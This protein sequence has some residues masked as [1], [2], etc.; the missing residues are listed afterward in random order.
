MIDAPR[1]GWGRRL[2]A[3]LTDQIILFLGF[4]FTVAGLAAAANISQTVFGAASF[5][6]T[7]IRGHS[8]ALAAWFGE[9]F[10]HLSVIAAV[11]AIFSIVEIPMTAAGGRTVGKMLFN[12]KIARPNGEPPGFKKALARW[13]LLYLPAVVPILVWMTRWRN[14]PIR[15]PYRG[16]PNDNA[17]LASIVDQYVAYSNAPFIVIGLLSLLYYAYLL[18]GER[19]LSKL[20]GTVVITDE[21]K[22]TSAP[23]PPDGAGM[24]QRLRARLLDHLFYLPVTAALLL[25]ITYNPAGQ[26]DSLPPIVYWQVPFVSLPEG[27]GFAPWALAAGWLAAGAVPALLLEV[28]LTALRGQTP[29]KTI[30]KIR[31]VR[32]SDGRPPGWGRSLARWAALYIPLFIPVV[33]WLIFPL[34]ALSPLFHPR[35]RGW[36]DLLAGTTAAPVE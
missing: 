33:G 9:P 11:L 30:M 28:P 34:T 19:G 1:A 20:T 8:F 14:L 10:F 15:E 25:L 21:D 26:A 3:R 31:A 7:L 36:H 13:G 16:D 5:G 24:T 35:R 4:I 17:A 2:G 32:A 22:I 29:G 6:H 27:A 12:I 18:F 23:Q